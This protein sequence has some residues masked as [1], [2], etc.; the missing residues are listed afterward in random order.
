MISVSQLVVG[1][2]LKVT[3]DD[4]G[5]E[6]IKKKTKAVLLKSKRKGDMY[7]L[8]F[9]S[10]KGKPTIFLLMKA[11]SDDCWLWHRKLSHLNIKDIN[12]LVIADLVHG[13]PLLK[14][15]K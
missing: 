12:K 9:N 13:L 2:S 14:F 8:D 15:E 3:F 7:P 10:I 6:I 11:T 5:L 4:E 1:T